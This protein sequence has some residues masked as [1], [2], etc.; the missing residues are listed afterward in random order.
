[1]KTPIRA[2]I[3]M[4]LL[5]MGLAALGWWQLGDLPLVKE[6]AHRHVD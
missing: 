1:M 6:E 2:A 5:A 4:V 3:L